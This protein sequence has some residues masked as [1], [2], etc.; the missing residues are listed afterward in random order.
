MLAGER[1]QAIRIIRNTSDTILDLRDCIN[2]LQEA[3]TA[4]EELFP[5][6]GLAEQFQKAQSKFPLILDLIKNTVAEY[7]GK[8]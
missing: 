2:D 4:N 1:R 8:R 5:W 7:V 6:D 3:M